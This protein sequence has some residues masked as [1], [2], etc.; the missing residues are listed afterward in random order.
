MLF[1]RDSNSIGTTMSSFKNSFSKL[2]R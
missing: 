2:N 1:D